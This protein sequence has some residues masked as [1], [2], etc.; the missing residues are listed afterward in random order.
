M[1]TLQS[2]DRTAAIARCAWALVELDGVAAAQGGT[3][4]ARRGPLT[5]RDAR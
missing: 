5:G 2:F 1:S 3:S 4:T